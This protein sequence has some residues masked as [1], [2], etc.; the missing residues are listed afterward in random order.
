LIVFQFVAPRVHCLTAPVAPSHRST[1]RA[2]VQAL[3]SLAEVVIALTL[4]MFSP[5]PF[6]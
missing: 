2:L 1:A 4:G 5:V 3:R 6:E